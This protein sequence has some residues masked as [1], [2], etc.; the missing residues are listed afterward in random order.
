MYHASY[1]LE[2]RKVNQSESQAAV[3]L[4]H[5]LELT[6]SFNRVRFDS[7]LPIISM[8]RLACLGKYHHDIIADVNAPVK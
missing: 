3:L 6:F 4:V 2:P 5:T 1:V 7:N 8:L